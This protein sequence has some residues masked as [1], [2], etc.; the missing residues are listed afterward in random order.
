MFCLYFI[1]YKNESDNF[2]LIFRHTIDTIKVMGL[3]VSIIIT[4]DIEN[5]IRLA[6]NWFENLMVLDICLMKSKQWLLSREFEW[7]QYI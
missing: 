6:T 2:C 4:F 1:I 5:K 3:Q 7:N